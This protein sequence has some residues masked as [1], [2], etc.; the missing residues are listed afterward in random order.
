MPYVNLKMIKNQ[1][2]S[3]KKKE[4]VR[5]LTDLIVEVMGRERKYTVITIDELEPSQWAIGGTLL[6]EEVSNQE[7]MM[8]VNIKVSKGTT[9]PE[10]MNKMIQA[11]K[12]LFIDIVGSSAMTNYV[13][14]DE[15]NPAGWGF[16]G[17]SMVERNK[18]EG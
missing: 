14:I 7:I 11:I 16:D 10:E 13:I 8:F 18:I 4:I 12:Q 2:S 15:L 1:V 6:D 3:E 5:G 17:I 9:N